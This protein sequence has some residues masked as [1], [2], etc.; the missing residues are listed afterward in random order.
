MYFRKLEID[1]KYQSSNI[2]FDYGSPEGTI[3][4]TLRGWM[5]LLKQQPK[6]S[7]LIVAKELFLRFQLDGHAEEPGHEHW[8]KFPEEGSPRWFI[9]RHSAPVS[10]T[11]ALW[12]RVHLQEVVKPMREDLIQQGLGS[13][14]SVSSNVD[15]DMRTALPHVEIVRQSSDRIQFHDTRTGRKG[16][17]VPK[18]FRCHGACVD[19]ELKFDEP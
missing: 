19:V 13:K 12:H 11:C 15:T 2:I 18:R 7:N 17:V 3:G 1:V 14:V 8:L 16:I 6:D 10:S 9:D 5:Q 4:F